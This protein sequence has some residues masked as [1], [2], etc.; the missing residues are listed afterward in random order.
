[1]HKTVSFHF[2]EDVV[3][4]C[5][6]CHKMW[7]KL[8][9]VIVQHFLKQFG[10]LATNIASLSF[11]GKTRV[12]SLAQ[13]VR[14]MWMGVTIKTFLSHVY[15]CPGPIE[16]SFFKHCRSYAKSTLTMCLVSW[17][18]IIFLWHQGKIPLHRWVN[19]AWG[20]WSHICLHPLLVCTQPVVKM[21]HTSADSAPLHVCP[22]L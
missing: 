12:V 22:G 10:H 7:S 1:M 5:S 14:Q 9:E 11:K 3:L 13:T 2:L 21:L 17:L 15:S 6:R 8:V 19:E 18:W 20:Q 16:S 4:L